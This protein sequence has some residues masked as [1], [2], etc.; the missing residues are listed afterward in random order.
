MWTVVAV[1]GV[2]VLVVT[3]PASPRPVATSDGKYLRR[4]LVGKGRPAC[5]PFL[6]HEMLSAQA[7]LG[8]FDYSAT[9]VSGVGFEDLDPL[10]VRTFP[11]QYPRTERGCGARRSEGSRTREG[12]RAIETRNGAVTVK[13]AGVLLFGRE[14]TLRAL[15]SDP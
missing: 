3:V 8:G 7:D 9:P 6:Y 14:E 4:A 2:E 11:P 15:R 12:A 13:A 1:D 5:V 10:R